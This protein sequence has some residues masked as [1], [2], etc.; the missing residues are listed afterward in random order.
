MIKEGVYFSIS[1]LKMAP[2]FEHFLMGPVYLQAND[3]NYYRPQ[4]GWPLRFAYGAIE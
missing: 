3:G 1:M 4:D 2:Y